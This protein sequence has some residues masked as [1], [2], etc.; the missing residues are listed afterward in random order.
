MNTE[1]RTHILRQLAGAIARR[2]LVAP[3]RIMLD[4]IAPVGFIASQVAQFIIPLTPHGRWRDYAS[5]LDDETG[6]KVLRQLVEQRDC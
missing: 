1:Q 3:A 5:A 6:W 4:V 2:H